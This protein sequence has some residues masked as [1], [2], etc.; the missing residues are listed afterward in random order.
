MTEWIKK[1]WYIYTKENYAAIKRNEIMSFE[2]TC[3]GHV[4]HAWPHGKREHSLSDNS[5]QVPEKEFN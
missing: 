4:D 2:R 3:I 1:M 5:T